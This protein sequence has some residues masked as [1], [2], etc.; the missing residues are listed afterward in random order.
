MAIYAV[1]GVFCF[2]F[3]AKTLLALPLFP[4]QM[5]CVEWTRGWLIMTIIDYYGA[6]LP[7]C[8]VIV[9]SEK[10]AKAALWCGE[11]RDALCCSF[12]G[13]AVLQLP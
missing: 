8:G 10:Q 6:V 13:G 12:S 3:L 11:P 2:A 7:L 5:G 4:F 1:L 9:A